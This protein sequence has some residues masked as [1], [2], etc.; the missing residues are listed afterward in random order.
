MVD[1]FLGNGKMILGSKMDIVSEGAYETPSYNDI[2][3]RDLHL[4]KCSEYVYA[5]NHLIFDFWGSEEILN[6]KLIIDSCQVAVKE[7]GATILHSHFHEF[8]EGMGITGVVV[9]SESHLSLHTWPEINLMTFDIYMCGDASPAVALE[10]LRSK[11]NPQKI[12]M[13]NLKRGAFK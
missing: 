7:A 9:L 4:I 6:Q 13:M 12:T 5:G 10:F 8:G 1:R 3:C 2:D 11:L